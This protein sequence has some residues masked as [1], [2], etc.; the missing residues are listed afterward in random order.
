[1]RNS[2]N[3]RGEVRFH[4]L[5]RMLLDQQENVLARQADASAR[6]QLSKCIQQR[7]CFLCL[8]DVRE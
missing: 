2:R 8:V 3:W 4:V 7:E 1:M 6:K 5:R